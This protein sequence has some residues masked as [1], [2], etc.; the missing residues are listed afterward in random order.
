MTLDF[1]NTIQPWRTNYNFL[2]I[3]REIANRTLVSIYKAYNIWQFAR[4]VR[5]IDGRAAEVGV[6]KGGSAKLLSEI[7]R[8]KSLDL[9]DTFSGLPK[10]DPD[11]DRHREGQ[12]D[13]TTLQILWRESSPF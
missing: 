10:H 11:K 13:D 8:G 12:F 9:F 2:K 4:S 5:N 7:F 6:Y 1:Y 3:Y